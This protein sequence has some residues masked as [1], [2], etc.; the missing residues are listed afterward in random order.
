MRSLL[1]CAAIAAAAVSVAAAQDEKKTKKDQEKPVIVVAGCLDGSW[2]R[3]ESGYGNVERYRL[4]GTKTLLKEMAGK[5]NGHMIEVTGAVT[6]T[7]NTTHRGKVIPVGKNG[8]I[9]TGAKEV[10]A[11][12]TGSGDPILDV[13]SFQELNRFCK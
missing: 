11:L 10:P 1:L 9:Y 4:H 7:G 8:R 6:D 3:V 5:H 12:P 13:A 2:L